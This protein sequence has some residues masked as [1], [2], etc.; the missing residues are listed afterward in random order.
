MANWGEDSLSQFLDM[1]HANQKA[2]RVNFAPAYD[3]IQ[4]INEAL[5]KAGKNLVNPQPV[6]AGIL[7]LRCQYAYKAA[8]GLALAGQVVETFAMMRSALEYAGYALVIFEDRSLEDVFISRH[9]SEAQMKIQKEKFKIS[10]VRATIARYDPK[11][12]ENFD[13]FYQRTIDFGGHPNPHATFSAMQMDERGGETGITAVALSTDPQILAHALKSV[14]QVGLTVLYILQH[15]FS[16]KFELL[17]IR[18]EIDAIR[19][20]GGL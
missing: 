3:T 7:L 11:L 4:R 8:A 10:N 17:G 19:N 13:T 16:A 12:A 2:N 20:Q 18:S 14:A 9:M 15:I 5:A 1:V 6:M